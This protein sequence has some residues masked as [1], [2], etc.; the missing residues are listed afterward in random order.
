MNNISGEEDI[1]DSCST[2]RKRQLRRKQKIQQEKLMKLD[3]QYEKWITTKLR[4]VEKNKG[5]LPALHFA[6]RVSDVDVCWRLL[7]QG[8]DFNEK[9]SIF[10][11]T[12][13]H[14]AAMNEAHG[15]RLIEFFLHRKVCHLDAEDAYHL[16]DQEKLWESPYDRFAILEAACHYADL[17]MC[18][19]LLE[20]VEIDVNKFE[21]ED[22]KNH[23][24]IDVAVNRKNEASKILQYLFSK[25][26]FTAA[27]QSNAY[28][29]AFLL[30]LGQGSFCAKEIEELFK[31]VADTKI[32]TE[33]KNLLQYCV[34]RNRLEA[35]KFVHEMDGELINEINEDGLTILHLA[36]QFGS[37]EMCRWLIDEGQDLYG[38]NRVTL[39]NFLHYATQNMING[40]D[41]IKT[42]GKDFLEYV[43]QIDK[44]FFTP[45]HSAM[46]NERQPDKVAEALLELGADLNVKW[47]GNNLLHFCV[48]NR[49]LQSAKF[50]DAKDKKMIKQRGDGGP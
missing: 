5:D 20:E 46:L 6:A 28:R 7:E 15:D 38:I 11:A 45:L 34:S 8:A 41:F 22:W 30:K 9:C 33:G 2:R 10:G 25:F 43:N 23:I 14:Y 32:R 37:V 3:E 42:F 47:K 49:K 21:D 29:S 27:Q 16:K 26:E 17:E 24:L 44:N 40:K 35:A 1:P 39:S 4:F 36:A 13:L 12:P 19:W 50:V 18:K 48:I 31:R